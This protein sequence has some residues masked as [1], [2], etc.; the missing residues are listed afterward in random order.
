M[1]LLFLLQS[2]LAVKT[3]AGAPPVRGEEGAARRRAR[4]AAWR[5]GGR[6]TAEGPA[7]RP[8]ASLS[9]ATAQGGEGDAGTGRAP[10]PSGP[11]ARAGRS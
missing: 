3:S 11:G 8:D 10:A 5:G 9:L 4:P 1:L 6:A 7:G 2:E